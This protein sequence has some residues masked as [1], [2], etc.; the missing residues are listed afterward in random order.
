M[1]EICTLQNMH[2]RARIQAPG[3]ELLELQTLAG[4]SLIW[5]G[6]PAWWP[7]RAPVLFPIVGRLRQDTLR[8]WGREYRMTQHGF[9]RDRN[10]TL[11]Q[12]S[13]EDC[14]WVLKDDAATRNSYPFP[15]ELRISYRLD[16]LSLRV[17]YEVRNPG[18]TPLPASLGAHPALPWP[19]LPNGD[20]EAHELRFEVPET[21]PVRRLKAGLLAAQTQPTPVQDRVLKLEDALFAEDALIFDQLRS[22]KVRFGVPGGP[23]LE[24]AWE[25]FKELGLWTKPGAP[26]LC[27]EPWHGTATPED[28]EGD[29]D[30]KPGIFS[31]PSGQCRRF[32]YTLSLLLD[33]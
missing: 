9:A 10:F 31:V 25:G 15:F 19:L 14:C 12:F 3:A 24:M 32:A 23:S 21:A 20:R 1:S 30:K 2:L 28:W 6:D 17:E 27:I 11:V 22:R 16:R 5:S 13:R 26:F 33:I 7:R 29:F 8:H 18:P 4:Q